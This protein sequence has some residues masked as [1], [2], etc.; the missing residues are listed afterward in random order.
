LQLWGPGDLRLVEQ[1]APEPKPGELL[2][3]VDAVGLCGSDRHWFEEGAI[4]DAVLE[5]PLVLGHEIAATVESGRRR[6][7]R[8]V[9]D[10][11][12]PCGRCAQCAAALGHL[13]PAVRFAGHGATDGGLRTLLAWSERLLHPVP[14]HVEPDEATL[15]E[16]LGVALHALEL[17]S[18]E[19][20]GR[21]AVV[22]CGPLGLL[23]VEL[24][25]HAGMRVCAVE[26]LPHRLA[27]AVERGAEEQRFEV[28]AAFEVA[29]TDEAVAAALE[30]TRPG[31]RVVLVGIPD[32][33]RTT[34]TASIA[35]R[36]GLTLLLS[37]RMTEND[38]R[39]A[40]DQVADGAIALDGLVTGRHR[41]DDADAAFAALAARRGLKTVIEV[42]A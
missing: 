16:P 1:P 28:D 37:R 32:G 24:L 27:A 8:V 18:L 29:G 20:G 23:L 7:E 36:K 40:I 10:P 4:G 19:R 35:R 30:L 9:V 38:F 12:D 2:L 33:D 39:R 22:G 6:G 34:L 26:P 21:A 25:V 42:A 15:L 41:L 11:A 17:A 5:R 3:R 13:C 14:D 31:G